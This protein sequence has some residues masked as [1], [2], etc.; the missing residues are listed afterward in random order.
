MRQKSM[1]SFLLHVFSS[2]GF[3]VTPNCFRNALA[4][5]AQSISARATIPSF[6]LVKCPR[7]LKNK[8]KFPFSYWIKWQYSWA[9]AS[10]PLLV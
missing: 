3:I 6:L 5:L 1:Y 2:S 4:L 8:G 10:I 9:K 7:S